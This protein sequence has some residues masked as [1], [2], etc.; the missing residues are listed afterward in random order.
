MP[1]AQTSIP[2][3]ES[4][5]PDV[6]QEAFD[7]ARASAEEAKAKSAAKKLRFDAL[8]MHMT[9]TNTL[10]V[11][12]IDEKG[13]RRVYKL[14]AKIVGKAES[15]PRGGGGRRDKTDPPGAAQDSDELAAKRTAK[16]ADKEA[17]EVEH[18]KR[19]R[20]SVESELADRDAEIAKRDA[21]ADPIGTAAAEATAAGDESWAPASSNPYAEDGDE[22]LGGDGEATYTIDGRDYTT[23][24]VKE[25]GLSTI[26]VERRASRIVGAD[27]RVYKNLGAVETSLSVADTDEQS[28]ITDDEDPRPAWLR[29]KTAARSGSILEEAEQRQDAANGAPPTM[30]DLDAGDGAASSSKPKVDPIDRETRAAGK[31]GLIHR[32]S[33]SIC[34]TQLGD[35]GKHDGLHTNASGWKW[36]AR[37]PKEGK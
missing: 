17:A 22:Q 19:S 27:G 16:K 26:E 33:G 24:Q 5:I 25:L 18:K 28:G 15:A 20:K 3:T 11:P 12:F 6:V 14:A 37:M 36:K 21:E 13:K 35:D 34:V 1:A 31:C 23:S 7:A 32:D 2:G 9:E 8:H 29:E 30:H 10:A 4:K